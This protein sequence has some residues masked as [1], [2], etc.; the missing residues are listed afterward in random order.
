MFLLGLATAVPSR[1]YTQAECLE[2]LRRVNPPQVSRRARA[3]LEGILGHDHGIERRAL[4][5]DTL[6]ECF[7]LDPDTLYRRFSRHAPDLASDAARKALA[8]AGVTARIVRIPVTAIF[9]IIARIGGVP[10]FWASSL[11]FNDK[12]QSRQ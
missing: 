6:D 2:A 4:A 3:L 11:P 12:C 5:L 1:R 9:R 8:E 10:F 7:D